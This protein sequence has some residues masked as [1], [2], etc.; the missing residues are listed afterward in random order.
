MVAVELEKELGL[1]VIA[2]SDGT[3]NRFGGGLIME[4][5]MGGDMHP[6]YRILMGPGPGVST[7]GFIKPCPIRSSG[8]LDPQIR[9]CMD[10]ISEMLRGVFQTKNQVTLAISAT[11]SSGMEAS[12]VNFVEPGDVVV[13]G[14]NGFFA[15]R[16]TQVASRCGA[17]VVRVEGEWG[18]IVEPER[19]IKAL[20]EHPEAKICGV[21]HAETS[22]GGEATP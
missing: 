2:A 6:S 22:T 7:T 15:D 9:A 10:E 17:Q 16:M 8:Y 4:K 18:K 13:I 14:V 3:E 5:W 1:K 11:G 19:V 20:K 21:V 12:Y